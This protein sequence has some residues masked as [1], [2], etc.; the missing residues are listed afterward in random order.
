MPQ[1]PEPTGA[2]DALMPFLRWA[3]DQ[4]SS[5]DAELK[6]RAMSDSNTNAS[7]NSTMST[8][9]DRLGTVEA[10]MSSIG[11]S[12]TI[13]ASQVTSGTFADARI[14]N[15][16]A[17]KITTGT[18]SR[19]VNTS[20]FVTS[21]AAWT[22]NVSGVTR[23]A[24]WMDSNGT[25]GNTGSTRRLKKDIEDFSPKDAAV[26]ALRLVR[27]RW[28]AGDSDHWEVGMIA[29]EVADLG[30]EWLIVRDEG[31]QP[32]AIHYDRLALALVPLIQRMAE[33]Q[34]ITSG[35]LE[36][37]EARLKALEEN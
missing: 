34:A 7:Q 6:R 10:I 19:P 23:L 22:Y 28:K 13:A 12:L 20:G 14:P 17:S 32:M 29:E 24:V 9:V 11:S 35:R 3:R 25:L 31:G 4:I 30:L 18:L 26:L 21:N 16:D 5:F 27:F 37:I 1:I 33:S 15:L 8:L 2:P 36:E